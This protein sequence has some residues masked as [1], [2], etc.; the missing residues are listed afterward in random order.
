MAMQ[1]KE[2]LGCDFAQQMNGEKD[3]V[4]RVRGKQRGFGW[5]CG[6]DGG[7]GHVASITRNRRINSRSWQAN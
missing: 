2:L 7:Q 5:G 3:V 6:V 1:A 4:G